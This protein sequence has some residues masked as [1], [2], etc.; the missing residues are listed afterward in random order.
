MTL[1]VLNHKPALGKASL[2]LLLFFFTFAGEALAQ[3]S[4]TDSQIMEF[5]VKENDK[6]TPRE[7]IFKKLIERGVS[8]D[9]IRRIRDKYEK[10]NK[11]NVMG[12]RNI[13]GSQ[14][15]D[16]MRKNNG[17]TKRTDDTEKNK[18]FQQRQTAGNKRRVNKS[19]MNDFQRKRYEEQEMDEYADAFD[20]VLPD[21]LDMMFPDKL[22][23]GKDKGK[24]K[25]VFGRNIFN[26]KNL[27]FESDMN[28]AIP[29]NYRLGPGDA[30]YIDIWGASEQSVTATVSPE[31][32]ITI[33]GCGPVNVNGLTVA[34]ANQRVK[35]V[36]QRH[37]AG[38]NIQLTVGQTKTISVNV[39]GE[40]QNPGT[41]TL[42][43]F[44]TVFHA[45]YM[46]GGTNDIGTLRNIKVYR[47]GKLISTVDIYDYILNGNLKGNVTLA[48][49]DVIAV[50][51]YDCLVDITGKV[52][53]PMVYE[54]KSNESLATLLKY[55][56]GFA[57]D[58]YEDVVHVVRKKG[59][60]FSVY[61]LDEYSRADFHM[62]DGDSVAVDS[63]LN[64]YTNMVEAKGAVMRPGKYQY[65][66]NITTVS[67]LLATAGGLAEN[68]YAEHAILRRRKADRSLEVLSIN[69]RAIMDHTQPDVALQNED[70]LFVPDRTAAQEERTLTI[71]GEV[72]YPG[73]YDFAE[74]MSV[75]DLILQAGGLKD[76]ASLVKVDVARRQRDKAAVTSSN[77]VAQMFSFKIKDGFT[78]D[79]E[80]DFIL[81]PFDEVYVR[82]SP[83]YVEQQHVTIQG[84]VA[85]P[86]TYTITKK[87]MRL[88]ELINMCGG[89]LPE[90]YAKGARLER[91][92]TEAEKIRQRQLLRMSTTSD[93]LDMSKLEISDIRFVGIY[94]DKALAN[95]GSEWDLVVQEGDRL[96]VPLFNNT[97]SV[98]GEVMYPNTVGFKKGEKLNYYINQS[99]G[100]SL[101][102]K[103]DRVFAIHM[104]GTVTRVKSAKDI[105]PGCEILVPAKRKRQQLSITQILSLGMTFV[106][107]GSVIVS[108]MK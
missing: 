41:Y 102:A 23:D 95:P 34:Q 31:G 96:I 55:A 73:T 94:L 8:V 72:I 58:A 90:G 48:S 36:M 80:K 88:S 18:N 67:Q 81:E 63:T 65:G 10:Q 28:V 93:S 107:L 37:Y 106:T 74:N 108:V 105:E 29:Q 7:E 61:S 104:N 60:R 44:A 52:K 92:L 12:G 86:G 64:R 35:G 24:K 22:G 103:K 40:V 39:M 11:N 5:V 13:D 79:G 89:I 15:I 56:G 98:Q 1:Q 101:R 25:E 42:S 100:Y 82:R 75:E 70:E 43:A 53:R 45:L 87:G 69:P 59:G 51:A 32:T 62:C 71:E 30:V 91:K 66:S 57:G 49:D 84:E 26:N 27:T 21:S 16:R 85:F 2:A 3:S 33:E 19:E 9:D 97:V 77:N 68:A 6:G 54:M 17:Q 78:I 38:S 76:A 47:G 83:D 14:T 20:F 46:A 99:G 4:M 50:D